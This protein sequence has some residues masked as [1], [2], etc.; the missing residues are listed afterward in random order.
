M[1]RTA[2]IAMVALV[3]AACGDDRAPARPDSV[4]A[5]APDSATATAPAAPRSR[6]DAGYGPVLFVASNGGIRAVAPDITDSTFASVRYRNL[7]GQRYIALTQGVG[8]PSILREGSTI[9][10]SRTAPRSGAGR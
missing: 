7:V 4:V 6:W 3:A 10:L 5:V 8:G 1:R 2:L 9:P